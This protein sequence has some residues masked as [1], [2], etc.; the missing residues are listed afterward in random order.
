MRLKEDNTKQKLRGGYY[1]PKKLADYIV[2]LLKDSNKDKKILEPSCGDGVFIES[3]VNS[4]D[5]DNIAKLK[6][7]EI[8]DEEANKVINMSGKTPKIEIINDDFL[9]QYKTLIEDEGFDL[10]VGNPPYIRYQ[11]LTKEQRDLQSEILVSNKMKS[12]KLINSWV[13]FL[14]ACIKLLNDKGKIGFII[15]AE[16]LQVAY[17]E[18]LRYFLSNHLAKITLITFKELVFPDIEQEVIVLIGEKNQEV[19]ID[20]AKISVKEFNNLDDLEHFSFGDLEYQYIEHTHEKWTKYFLTKEQ[21]EM[22]RRLKND[23]RFT[24]F[25]SL[26]I[27][28]VGITTGNNKYFSVS[29]D[30]VKKYE[31]DNVVLPLIGRSSHAHGINFTKEDWEK[32][33]HK[34][35]DAF[36][37]HF[38]ED[39]KIEDYNKKHIEY[40]KL[41]EK[42]EENKGYKCRIR[43]R[44]YIVPSVWVP[45]AFFLR[46]N[47]LYPKF[48]L[49]DID[50]VST[51]T[52]H[53]IKFNEGIDKNKVLLS[54]YNSVTLAFTE[55]NGR[56]YGG[57]VLEILPREVGAVL[58]P[59]IQD[60]D[61]D[62]TKELLEIIDTNIRNKEDINEVLDIMDHEILVKHVG[63]TED[64]CKTFRDIWKRLMNRRHSRNR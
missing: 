29:E 53:R 1:T 60:F 28:N 31:L 61:N 11:Y 44:W 6:G 48:V 58:L 17:A 62:R 2:E 10:I 25:D 13:C 16:I 64:E 36:L 41:G 14:V 3:I 43:D 38:P 22:I 42:K 59:K 20:E 63:L 5:F 9:L 7:I 32:N 18:D 50:A 8:I 39:I 54:Y 12:N 46:R 21:N 35:S 55:I 30:V 57:G 47:N 26:G 51:D 34:G 27:V 24:T 33:I 4:Y 40:I 15:P 45:D 52:M 19:P 56:S 37:I 23:R 49:N